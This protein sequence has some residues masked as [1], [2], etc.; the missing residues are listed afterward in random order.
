MV[1]AS[2]SAA[3][4]A[5][6]RSSRLRWLLPRQ[7]RRVRPDGESGQGR[8]TI[9]VD[10]GSVAPRRPRWCGSACEPRGQCRFRYAAVNCA[11]WG[12]T[13][14]PG[15]GAGAAAD[16]NPLSGK[17]LCMRSVYRVLAYLVALEVVI[18]TALI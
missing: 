18:Q 3:E 10:G 7:M 14:V 4:N 13:P 11:H 1:D 17:E 2:V 6:F 16:H 5:R 9:H 12:D 15:N 8:R